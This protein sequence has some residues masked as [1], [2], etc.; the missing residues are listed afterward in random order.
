MIDENQITALETIGSFQ[1]ISSSQIVASTSRISDFK[2]TSSI[3]KISPIA[4]EDLMESLLAIQMHEVLEP[5]EEEDI[6]P[7]PFYLS[8]SASHQHKY[9]N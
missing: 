9:I 6:A 2:S 8:R 1:T 7:L 4:S 5:E 3:F